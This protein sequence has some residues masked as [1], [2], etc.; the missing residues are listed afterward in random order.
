[1][2][3]SEQSS[4]FCYRILTAASQWSA[5]LSV[6][7]AISNT[8]TFWLFATCPHA[9]GQ[10]IVDNSYAS[11]PCMTKNSLKIARF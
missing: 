1:M 2:H 9:G 4:A 10:L 8:V 5:V 7:A 3:E 11:C 6:P